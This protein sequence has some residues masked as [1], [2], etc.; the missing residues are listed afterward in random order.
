M[1]HTFRINIGFI[2]L[3][4]MTQVHFY[5]QNVPLSSLYMFFNNQFKLQRNIYWNLTNQANNV[6]FVKCD[7]RHESYTPLEE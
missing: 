2:T 3:S 4:T 5:F 6:R 7:K 1:E